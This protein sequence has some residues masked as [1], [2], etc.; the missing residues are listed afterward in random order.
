MQGGHARMCATY[1]WL[2]TVDWRIYSEGQ[3]KKEHS[4]SL[5]YS[6]VVANSGFG[7]P[8]LRNDS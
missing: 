4:G 5:K 8:S 2:L 6:S 3:D 7:I 1:K